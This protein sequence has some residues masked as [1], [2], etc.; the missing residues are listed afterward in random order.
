MKL[1][2]NEND[3]LIIEFSRKEFFQLHSMVMAIREEYEAFE[4]ETVRMEAEEVRKFLFNLG[5]I[6]QKIT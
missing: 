2:S 4:Y 1:L 5:N 3:K 6:F